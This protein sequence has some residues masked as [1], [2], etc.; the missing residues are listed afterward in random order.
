MNLQKTVLSKEKSISKDYIL[1]NMY[2]TYCTFI[3]HSR[4]DKIIEMQNRSA[5]ARDQGWG[6]GIKDQGGPSRRQQWL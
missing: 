2:C 5:V 1:Y 6:S 3:Q 4:N